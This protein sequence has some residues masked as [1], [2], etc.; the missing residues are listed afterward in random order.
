MVLLLEKWLFRN[1]VSLYSEKGAVVKVPLYSDKGAVIW[2]NFIFLFENK[3]AITFK[4]EKEISY[5]KG[6]IVSK[7]DI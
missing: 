1:I 3:A 2:K 4:L 7:N 5:L 6:L